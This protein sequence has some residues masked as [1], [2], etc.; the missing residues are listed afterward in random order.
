[1]KVLL[2]SPSDYTLDKT[3]KIGFERLGFEVYHH[4]FRKYLKNWQQKVNTQIFRLPFKY[5]DKW[6]QY[7]LPL[8]NK[9]HIEIFNQQ[10]P[11]VVFI[12][13][14]E[15]L[16]P[17]TVKYFKTQKAKIIFLLGDSPYFTPMNRFYMHLFFLA[18]LII[19]PDSFWA[20]QLKLI[21]LKNIVVDFP[22]FDDSL[23][24]FR[25]PT[26]EER[27]KFNFDVLF[28]GIGY[29]D[30]W[31][32]KR[33]LFVS[34][35]CNLNL[36]VFGN[37]HWLKWFEFFPELKQKFELQKQ[38]MGFEELIIMSKCAKVYPVDANPAVLNGLHLRVLDCI[39]MGVLPLVEYRKDHDTFFNGVDIPLIKNYD[40]AESI[41]VKYLNNVNLREH[42]LKE[43]QQF[44]LEKFKPEVVLKRTLSKL[45]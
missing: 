32:Y 35:F 4:N 22:G 7:Y 38:R 5:R 44:C 12:Y 19:S 30:A 3:I 24:N 28:V 33:T 9:K 34:K 39:A 18:D 13:N 16:L 37:K 21:G 43:L 29:V 2:L 36:K 42:T 14:S 6:E 40:E 15:M 26:D 23:L 20:E 41:A 10:K 25:P 11:D 1:M 17:D 27:T 8:I 45:T 31:G